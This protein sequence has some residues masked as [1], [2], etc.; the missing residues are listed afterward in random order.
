MSL[1]VYISIQSIFLKQKR[2]GFGR[3][4]KTAGT[5]AQVPKKE[6]KNGNIGVQFLLILASSLDGNQALIPVV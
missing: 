1:L 3:K 6:N 2:F 4:V 5:I